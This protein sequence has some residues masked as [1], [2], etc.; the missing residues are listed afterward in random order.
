MEMDQTK[1][2]AA[3]LAALLAASEYLGLSKKI[4]ENAVVEFVGN[5]FLKLIGKK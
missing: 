4:Q 1:L 2:I 3:L 5:F